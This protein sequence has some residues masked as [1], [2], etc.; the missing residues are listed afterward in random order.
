MENNSLNEYLIFTR[1]RME[2]EIKGNRKS[3]KTL[4]K[5]LVLELE[6]STLKIRNFL[7]LAHLLGF[8]FF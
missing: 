1:N 6:K 8:L 7:V 5:L 4:K 2:F 3:F